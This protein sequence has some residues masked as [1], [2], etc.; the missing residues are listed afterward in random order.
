M[1]D[2]SLMRL[3]KRLSRL[4]DRAARTLVVIEGLYSVLGDTAPMKEFVE[5]K[6]RHDALL[7]VD[8]A[9]S[10][11][12]YGEHGRGVVESSETQDRVDFVVG[13]DSVGPQER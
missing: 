8:E 13:H 12:V 3:D 1:F 9:H 7:M 4:K 5:V 10:L 11:G 2:F 6:E